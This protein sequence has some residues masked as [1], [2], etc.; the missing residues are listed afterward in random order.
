MKTKLSIIAIAFVGGFGLTGLTFADDLATITQS[1]AGNTADVSQS[2]TYTTLTTA[3]VNQDG[4]NNAASV[5]QHD[6]WNAQGSIS[7]TGDNNTAAITQDSSP[8]G[9]AN[10]A[11]ATI[12][13]DGTN[14]NATINQLGTNVGGHQT[15]GAV[16]SITQDNGVQN[17]VALINQTDLS[18]RSSATIDQSGVPSWGWT[19]S[20]SAQIDQT[21]PDHVASI[22]QLTSDGGSATIGQTGSKQSATIF[23]QDS[24]YASASVVQSGDSNVA[25]VSQTNVT[26]IS[27]A[28]ITQNGTTNNATIAQSGA[29]TRQRVSVRWATITMVWLTNPAGTTTR[30]FRKTAPTWSPR[31]ISPA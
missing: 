17:A 3:T 27:S 14:N 30:T 31:S 13:Q 18:Q 6:V 2:L 15:D 23:E 29:V 10:D 8:A 21:G 1:G 20:N 24:N 7:T 28:D 22:S 9:F 4:N 19:Y 11:Q 5:T 12:L 26:Q 16:A 25:K